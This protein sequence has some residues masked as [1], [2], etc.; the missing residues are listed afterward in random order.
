[1]RGMHHEHEELPL[2]PGAACQLQAGTLPETADEA[3]AGRSL[4]SARAALR[5]AARGRALS[6]AHGP[7]SWAK[8]SL[9]SRSQAVIPTAPALSVEERQIDMIWG[10][11]A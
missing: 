10:Y 8:A 2:P 9:R 7:N 4:R 1:M 5:S 6:R 11:L 3:R